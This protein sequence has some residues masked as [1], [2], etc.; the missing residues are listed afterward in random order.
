MKWAL[1]LG[2]AVFVLTLL[3]IMLRPKKSCYAPP[4]D[5]NTGMPYVEKVNDA[6][7]SQT[8]VFKDAAGWLN[9][10]EHPMTGFIQED[11]FANVATV[12]GFGDFVGLESS[13]GIAPM[14]VIPKDE[15]Y[16]YT[17]STSATEYGQGI[18]SPGTPF[19]GAAQLGSMTSPT[20]VQ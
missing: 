20:A 4:R 14:T 18:T 12:T 8:E 15:Q 16:E 2:I 3:F 13:A 7:D 1:G 9:M 19:I 10:R 11:A 17:M 6:R 5:E